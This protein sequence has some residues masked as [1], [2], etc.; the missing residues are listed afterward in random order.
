M[1]KNATPKSA[2]SPTRWATYPR[3]TA[4]GGVLLAVALVMSLL[5]SLEALGALS[6]PGCGQGSPCARAAAS[7]WGSVPGLGWPVSFLGL[8]YFAGA[9]AAWAMAGGRP[10]RTGIACVRAAAA[11][12]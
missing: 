1:P 11:V 12:S 9:L 2:E 3:L 8:A 10:G 5:L 4:A 6:L 7:A